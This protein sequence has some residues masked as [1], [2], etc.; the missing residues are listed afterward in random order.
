MGNRIAPPR[1]RLETLLAALISGIQR[2]DSGPN[3]QMT[4][5]LVAPDV[6]RIRV[7]DVQLTTQRQLFTEHRADFE[8]CD[9]SRE[10]NLPPPNA[11]PG[12]T[13][14]IVTRASPY[15]PG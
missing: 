12:R 3:L 8:D 2:M 14:G 10:D 11:G 1:H 13:V 5:S 6:S 7:S 9:R 15:G 4:S